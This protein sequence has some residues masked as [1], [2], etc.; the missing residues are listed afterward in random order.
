[1]GNGGDQL[2][3]GAHSAQFQT[4]QVNQDEWNERVGDG[5]DAKQLNVVSDEERERLDAEVR[6][7]SARFEAEKAAKSEQKAAPTL[8]FRA[9]QDRIVVARLDEEEKVNGLFVPDEGKEKPQEGIV[10]AVGPGKYVYGN[11]VPTSVQPGERVL[12]GKFA[13]QEVKVGFQMFLVLREED[14]FIVKTAQS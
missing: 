2:A 11:F 8:P 4:P 7:A 3:R 6:E 10:V 14:I 9:V 13:G 12:F 1:M 5:A